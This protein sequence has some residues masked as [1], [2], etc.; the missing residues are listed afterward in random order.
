MTHEFAPR[1][2]VGGITA[3]PAARP[4]VVA[5]DAVVVFLTEG[6]GGSGAAAEVDRATGGLLTKLVAAGDIT[7][8]RNECVPLLAPPGMAAGYD[9]TMEDARF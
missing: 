2:A 6:G 8:K 5:A 4:E 3:E 1:T 7:A 9:V